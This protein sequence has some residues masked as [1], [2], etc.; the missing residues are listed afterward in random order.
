MSGYRD[1]REDYYGGR[2]YA[3]DERRGRGYERDGRDAGDYRDRDYFRNDYGTGAVGHRGEARDYERRD[4]RPPAYGYRGREDREGRDERP[5]RDDGRDYFPRRGYGRG[6][7]S[8]SHLR[9]R[10][11]MTRDVTVA[12]RDATLEEVARMMRDEDTGVI[13][14]VEREGDAPAQTGAANGAAAPG[15]AVAAGRGGEGAAARRGGG[16]GL[17]GNGRLVGLITDRDIVVRA[18]AEGRD[19]RSTRAEEIM[20]A[21]VHAA[22]PNDRVIDAIRK[23]GDKQVRRI[24]IVDRDGV[25]RGIISMA[26]VAL[27]TND[28][29]EL[30]EALEEIS[31]GHSFWNRIFG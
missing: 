13:P 30:A 26:D 28:D 11:I 25:L 9:C 4:E 27:E 10:D 14:V 17:H 18:L 21:E 1:D 22:H 16:A 19:A 5:P 23:M 24:P 20:T 3:E 31:S 8:R 7:T 6:R 15:G 29:R 2:R 12:T